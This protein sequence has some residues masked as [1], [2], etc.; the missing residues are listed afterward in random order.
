MSE[1]D[2]CNAKDITTIHLKKIKG[3]YYAQILSHDDNAKRLDDGHWTY[4]GPIA[5]A[6]IKNVY[7]ILT[8]RL[9]DDK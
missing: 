8:E 4:T 5:T 6:D 2:I 1:H 7:Y 3:K 9:I